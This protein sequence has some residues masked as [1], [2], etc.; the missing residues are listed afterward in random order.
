MSAVKSFENNV[1]KGEIARNEHFLLFPHCFSFPFGELTAIF[2]TNLI[3]GGQT[4]C[5][6]LSSC[7]TKSKIC[8]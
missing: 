1:G 4:I 2:I 6:T 5:K 3:N 7:G 8:R